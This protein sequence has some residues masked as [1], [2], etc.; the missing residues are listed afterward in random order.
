MFRI[1]M[2]KEATPTWGELYSC[3]NNFLKKSIK[4]VFFS[5]NKKKR[6]KNRDYFWVFWCGIMNI[7]N[8]KLVHDA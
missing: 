8:E 4:M 2:V 7:H 3:G 1:A 5:Y 6:K